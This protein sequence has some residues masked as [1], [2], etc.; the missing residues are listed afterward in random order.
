MR[1]LMRKHRDRPTDLADAALVRV[2]E[3]EK[4]DSIFTIDREDFEVY[5]PSRSWRFSIFPR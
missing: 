4:V 2:A 3:P 1:T 5:H